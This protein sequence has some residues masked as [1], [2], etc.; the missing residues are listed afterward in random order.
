MGPAVTIN[1]PKIP[2][3]SLGMF[4]S[5]RNKWSL[6]PAKITDGTRFVPGNSA[7]CGLF[8]A[9]RRVHVTRTRRLL[10]VTSNFLRNKKI[11][12]R[13]FGDSLT[14]VTPKTKTNMGNGKSLSPLVFSIEKLEGFFQPLSRWFCTLPTWQRFFGIWRF[15][16]SFSKTSFRTNFTKSMLN[17]EYSRNLCFFFE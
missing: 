14:Q 3:V 6:N 9:S 15:T 7:K 8:L 16:T 1:W 17:C 10:L 4:F 13:I 12:A 11:T 5:P 2:W